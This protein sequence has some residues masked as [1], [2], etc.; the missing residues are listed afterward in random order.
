MVLRR[1]PV[2][3]KA[4]SYYLFVQYLDVYAEWGKFLPEWERELVS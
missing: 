3:P 4:T 1:P 2:E